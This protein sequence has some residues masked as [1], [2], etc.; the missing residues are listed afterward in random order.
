MGHVLDGLHLVVVEWWWWIFVNGFCIS[1]VLPTALII[2]LMLVS[3]RVGRGLGLPLLIWMGSPGERLLGR[4]SRQVAIGVGLAVLVWQVVLAGYLAEEF[5]SGYTIDRPPYCEARVVALGPSTARPILGAEPV[6]LEWGLENPEEFPGRFRFLPTDLDAFV[7]Y[8]AIVF[9]SLLGTL[10]GIGAIVRGF[11]AVF[12]RSGEPFRKPWEPFAP[13]RDSPPPPYSLWLPA[14]FVVGLALMSGT[15]QFFNEYD[16]GRAVADSIGEYVT[17]ELGGWGHQAGRQAA[18]EMLLEARRGEPQDQPGPILARFREA[19]AEQ[20]VPGRAEWARSDDRNAS[21]FRAALARRY[22]DARQDVLDWYKPYYPVFGL[23]VLTSLAVLLFTLVLALSGI[24]GRLGLLTP[25][26]WIMFLMHLAVFLSVFFSYFIPLNNQFG[27]LCLAGLVAL[28]GRTYKNRFPNLE[29]GERP[30]ELKAAYARIAAEEEAE[31]GAEVEVLGTGRPSPPDGAWPI[32]SKEIP[33]GCRDEA[34]GRIKPPVALV[35][36]SGGGSR[37][38]LWV[39]SVLRA[40]EEAF[41]DDGRR[42]KVAFPYHVRLISGASGGMLGAAA[43]AAALQAPVEG[44]WAAG[45][46][47]DEDARRQTLDRLIDGIQQNFLSPVANHLGSWDLLHAFLPR[48]RSY[49]RGWAIEDAWDRALPGVLDRTFADLSEGER[50]GWRPSLI[51]SP[52]LVED[53]R[54]LFISNLSLRPVT[55]NLAFVAGDPAPPSGAGSGRR[56]LSREGVEFFDLFPEAYDRFRV[57]TAARMSAS[58]PYVLPAAILPTNPPRRVVDAGYYDN[59]GVGIAVSWLSTHLDWIERNT[60][61]VILIQI[62]D[63]RSILSRRREEVDDP[64]PGLVARGV[65]WAT[66]PPEGLWQARVASHVYRNDHLLH[67]MTEL[68]RA[69]GFPDN[70]FTTAT[71][72]FERGENVSLSWTLTEQEAGWIDDGVGAIANQV[73]AVVDWWH[74]RLAWPQVK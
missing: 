73:D 20:P 35:C 57:G 15:W 63:G 66:S 51:F 52:M 8:S 65:Q 39:S 30:V 67:L 71:F 32:R 43:Y 17:D 18:L 42:P 68:V 59:Y 24:N 13:K 53:G 61:G 2:L 49:D 22:A 55:W 62:R 48:R 60:S 72:E 56:L 54:Q 46:S 19:L 36:V 74:S 31:G 3:G 9:L 29:F 40:L 38:A 21:N 10:V 33:Y 47:S 64:F 44:R 41:L 70:F 16:A 25:A 12:G 5:A 58:F 28:A 69:R 4:R 26:G 50:R 37:S 1:V 45:P 14:G 6:L 34:G 23:F 27:L 7:G 11:Q